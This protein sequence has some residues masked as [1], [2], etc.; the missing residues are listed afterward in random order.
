MATTHTVSD[1]F[2][3]YKGRLSEGPTYNPSNHTLL[4]V[5]IIAGKIHRVHLLDGIKGDNYTPEEINQVENSHEEYIVPNES[6]GV[7]YLVEGN[8]DLIYVGA[9]FGIAT[10]QFS[11]Q[12]F[13]Y[14][15]KYPQGDE[16]LRSN[17][18]N[19]DPSGKYIFAGL[20]GNFEHGPIDNG[21]LYKIDLA[22]K[23]VKIQ[24][25]N[26]KIPNGINWSK[27]GKTVYWTSSLDHTIYKFDY[28]TE[29]AEL[30][31]QTP[32]IK[33]SDFMEGEPDGHALTD[34]GHIFTA[35]WGANAVV[36]FDEQGQLVEQYKLPANQVSAVAFASSTKGGPLDEVYVTT[37][38]KNLE[39]P[40]R[41]DE[42]SEDLGGA[43]FRIKLKGQKGLLRNSLKP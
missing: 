20:M 36:H 17:D 43:I 4:W 18:G 21:K 28:D 33:I 22:S 35:V 42:N 38:N 7:I 31:N 16:N 41:L 32:H 6:I 3:N 26:A 13:E 8:D 39:D 12:K 1:V 37:A 14:V 40:D 34:D 23:D 11:T 19:V 5:D 27:D 30:K 24:V 15:L 10:Y 29:T 2:L 9:Q 25:P